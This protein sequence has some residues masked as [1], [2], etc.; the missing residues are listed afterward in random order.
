MSYGHCKNIVQLEFFKKDSFNWSN[1]CLLPS[2]HHSCALVYI[3][4]PLFRLAMPNRCGLVF[5][6][7][8]A[9]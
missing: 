9:Q 4:V 7:I 3:T 2:M 8:N 6:L 1:N 5:L